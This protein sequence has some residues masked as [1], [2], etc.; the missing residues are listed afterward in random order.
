MVK[1]RLGDGKD[2]TALRQ[3]DA[4]SAV[5]DAVNGRQFRVLQG[6]D[7]LDFYVGCSGLIVAEDEAHIVGYALTHLVDR[8]HGGKRLVWLEHI[9]V[10]PD[11]RRRGVA[12]EILDYIADYY[13][14]R[15]ECIHASIHPLNKASRSL[16]EKH[17]AESVERIEVFKLL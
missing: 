17:G 15:A 12:S 8:M 9:G 14:G 5:A 6:D 2:F 4:V 7:L 13:R 10:H 11:Y 3:L 16:F 1:V